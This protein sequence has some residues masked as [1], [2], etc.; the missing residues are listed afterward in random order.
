SSRRPYSRRG[1]RARPRSSRG[2]RP[3]AA[4]APGSGASLREEVREEPLDAVAEA[5]RAVAGVAPGG[6]RGRFGGLAC[7]LQLLPAILRTFGDRA[8]DA[9]GRFS[10]ALPDLAVGDLLRP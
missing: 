10:D 2:P 5:D 1:S 4:P 3:G 6:S 9:L 7:F 8:A